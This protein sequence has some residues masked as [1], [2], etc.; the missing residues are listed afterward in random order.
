[1]ILNH[2]YIIKLQKNIIIPELL[3]R[4]PSWQLL[5]TLA[6]VG[7]SEGKKK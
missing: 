3:R 4:I 6:K 1:M 5:R 7:E 2:S